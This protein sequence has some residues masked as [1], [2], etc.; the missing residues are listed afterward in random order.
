MQYAE[1]ADSQL[2]VVRLVLPQHRI[3]A[4]MDVDRGLKRLKPYA[5][6]HS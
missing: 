2:T 5:S 4:L 6:C 1:L 3:R